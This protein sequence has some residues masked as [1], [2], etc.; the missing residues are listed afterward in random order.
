MVQYILGGEPGPF[1]RVKHVSYQI[2]G[3]VG[4]LPVP[5]VEYQLPQQNVVQQALLRIS[6]IGAGVEEQLVKQNPQAVDIH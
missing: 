5:V 2:F 3:L 6:V 1:V 4:Y